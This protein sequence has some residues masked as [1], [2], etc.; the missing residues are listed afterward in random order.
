MD[1]EN[2]KPVSIG[3]NDKAM[4]TIFKQGEHAMYEIY[5]SEGGIKLTKLSG[6]NCLSIMPT[7]DE[8]SILIK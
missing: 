5:F 3:P 6:D 4:F 2:L 1:S 7:N 8:D